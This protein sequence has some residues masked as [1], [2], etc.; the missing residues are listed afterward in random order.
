MADSQIS[1]GDVVCL[2][3]NPDVKMTVSFVGTPPNGNT[4]ARVDWLDQDGQARDGKFLV[5]QLRTV[6][7]T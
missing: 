3:S 4:Y 2:A 7:G 6:R 1:V 5:E